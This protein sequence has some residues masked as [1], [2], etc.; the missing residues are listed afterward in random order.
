M[1]K[2]LKLNATKLKHIAMPSD[3]TSSQLPFD[4]VHETAVQREDLIESPANATAI[5]MIDAWPNWPGQLTILAGPVGSGK[6]HIGSVWQELS[7]ATKTQSS[8]LNSELSELISI[9]ENGGNILLEDAGENSLDE[10][11]L[12]HLFNAVKQGGSYCLVTAR[13][14]PTQWN[15]TLPD[16]ASR[17]KAAQLIELQEPDDM[18]LKLV[19]MKLFSDRQVS[20]DEKVLDYCVVRMERSLASAANLVAEI[21]AE[22]LSRKTSVSKATAAS[23]LSKLN[24]I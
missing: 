10:T 17:L 22:A 3:K 11:A 4:L 1:R 14:W 23:A 12:F 5:N 20:V 19:M 9:A 7:Q 8:N 24:M 16:L 13:T 2:P 21:D 18:L 15:V 6:S